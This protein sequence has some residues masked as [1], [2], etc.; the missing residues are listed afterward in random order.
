MEIGA[1]KEPSVAS[2]CYI[3]GWKGVFQLHGEKRQQHEQ[4]QG[5]FAGVYYIFFLFVTSFVR[6][7]NNSTAI[8]H[9]T[10]NCWVNDALFSRSI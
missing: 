5:T 2:V 7:Y 6:F 3:I 1:G 9:A 8:W 4:D 10:L